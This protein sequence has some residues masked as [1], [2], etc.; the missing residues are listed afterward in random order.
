MQMLCVRKREK[1]KIE[2]Q[3]VFQCAHF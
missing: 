1:E 2:T 3:T